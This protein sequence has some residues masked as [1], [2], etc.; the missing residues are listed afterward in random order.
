MHHPNARLQLHLHRPDN[1]GKKYKRHKERGP[2]VTKRNLLKAISGSCGLVM[3]V[4]RRLQVT[5]VTVR[6]RLKQWPECEA[7]L[8]KESETFLDVAEKTVMNVMKGRDPRAKLEAAKFALGTKGRARGWQKITTLEGGSKPVGIEHS[9]AFV[10]TDSLSLEARK[11]LFSS[12]AGANKGEPQQA[13]LSPAAPEAP[14]LGSPL[15]EPPAP[16][17]TPDSP[18]ASIALIKTRV[19]KLT[20]RK[21]RIVKRATR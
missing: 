13:T 12:I 7:A 8:V 16:V 1:T 18:R 11:I 10:D 19:R 3:K 5:A 4:A 17:L 2:D 15:P 21:I 9:G 14:A 6:N 20:L